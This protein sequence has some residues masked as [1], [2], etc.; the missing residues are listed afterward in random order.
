MGVERTGLEEKGRV[1]GV[2]RLFFPGREPALRA[3]LWLSEEY[4]WV[5]EEQRRIGRPEVRLPCER[6]PAGLEWLLF[7]KSDLNVT[8]CTI[9]C[10]CDQPLQAALK[11]DHHMWE[12]PPR[13]ATH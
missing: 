6:R 4:L 3:G 2:S 5:T 8:P 9:R 10:E 1:V 12:C 13:C 7:V 11:I